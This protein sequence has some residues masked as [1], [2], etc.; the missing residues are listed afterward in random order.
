MIIF[1]SLKEIQNTDPAVVALGNFDGIHRGHRSLIE[2]ATAQAREKGVKSAVFTFQDHPRNVL[3]G[4]IVVRNIIYPDVKMELLRSLGVDYVFSIPFDDYMMHQA[5][6]DFVKEIMVG[7]FHAAGAVCGTN[8]T[9]GYKAGGNSE[10]LKKAGEKYGFDVTVM[11]M[12][13]DGGEIVSSTLIRQCVAEGD[14]ERA[15]DLLGRCYSIRGLV[16]KG[17][18]IGRTIG[19]PTCNI[20]V[21][22]TMVTPPNGVY[23]TRSLIGGELYESITNV[24]NKPT[25]GL[26]GKNIETNI[27]NFDRDVYDEIIEVFFLKKHRDE[28]RFK[29]LEELSDQLNR[30]RAEALRFLKAERDA[31]DRRLRGSVRM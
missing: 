13:M 19:F 5:P 15:G 25:V 20:S 10:D 17:N 11:P 22:Q 12:V 26:Y 14:M 24:G 18:Q 1:N 7:R 4:E 27:L 2:T 28:V 8:F 16:I 6:E 30:D 23:F 31:V 3:A 21:D 9:Y 29:G